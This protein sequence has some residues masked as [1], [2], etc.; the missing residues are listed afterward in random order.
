MSEGGEP[1]RTVYVVDDDASVRRALDRLFRHAGYTV[2]AFASAEEF[3][4]QDLSNEQGCVIADVHLGGMRGFDLHA[5]LR[6]RNNPM[7]VILISG[8]ESAAADAEVRNFGVTEFFRKPFE[9]ERLMEVV[10]RS[11][12]SVLSIAD[13]QPFVVEFDSTRPSSGEDQ[14]RVIG[15]NSA[16]T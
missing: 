12:Q 6:Q 2:R 10:S 3:L 14:R 8:V 13:S 15:D 1:T 4:L 16:H 7:R 11:F 5:E 9:V